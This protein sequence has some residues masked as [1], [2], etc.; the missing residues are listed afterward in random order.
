MSKIRINELARELEVKPTVII[1]LMA[2][3]ADPDV[4]A[5]LA[6]AADGRLEL[7]GRTFRELGLPRA[8]AAHRAMLAYS[9]YLGLAELRS[10][11]PQALASSTRIRAYLRDVESTLLHDV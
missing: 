10:Q 7:L 9:A 3:D 8:G 4:A 2:A 11:R 1:R 5:A 6:R